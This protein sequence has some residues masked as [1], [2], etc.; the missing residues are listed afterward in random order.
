MG[1]V[2]PEAIT[3]SQ[4]GRYGTQEILGLVFAQWCIELC[5]GVSGCM[6]LGILE[7]VPACPLVFGAVSL[8]LWWVEQ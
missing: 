4:V 8:V 7:L 5:P 6:A 1:E 3:G 2:C